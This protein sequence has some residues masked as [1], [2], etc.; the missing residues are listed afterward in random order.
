MTPE[1]E[2]LI[3]RF[4]PHMAGELSANA[5]KGD[6]WAE[7]STADHAFEVLYHGAKLALAVAASDAEA[8]REL[9][10]DVAN[11]AAMLADAA[12]VLDD[13]PTGDDRR[14]DYGG[15]GG[16]FGSGSLK[17]YV[18]DVQQMLTAF[19]PDAMTAADPSPADP[20]DIAF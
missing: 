4:V 18:A 8:I 9:A 5:H 19:G 1:R 7:M 13:P 11:H 14:D 20:E 6:G 10:A 17:S 16:T 2:H 3:D 12:N 15:P